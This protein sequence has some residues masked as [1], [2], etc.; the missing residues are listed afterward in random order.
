[1][2]LFIAVRFGQ[3]TMDKLVSLRDELRVNSGRGNFTP[4]ENLHLTL[5]FIGECDIKQT[6]SVKNCVDTTP[7]TPFDTVFDRI[8]RFG[9]NGGDI[10]WAGVRADNALTDLQKRLTDGF[11]QAGFS[12]DTRAYSPHV[13]LGREV[14]TI[15]APRPVAPFGETARAVDVMKS[16]R[17]DGR[18]VYTS[19]YRKTCAAV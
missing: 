11:V 3:N 5:V 2:R 15:I 16:E 7:F 18:L 17:V 19:I 12:V 4:D 9:R 8:G 13:T 6:E 1:M 14:E 10:W